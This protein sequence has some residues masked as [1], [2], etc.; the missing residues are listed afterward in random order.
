MKWQDPV[1]RRI[2]LNLHKR[3]ELLERTM[4]PQRSRQAIDKVIAEATMGL[5]DEDLDLLRALTESQTT[6]RVGALTE[7][8]WLAQAKYLD[9]I[10]RACRRAGW[11][12]LADFQE[13]WATTHQG[14]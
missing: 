14:P 9:L 2:A 13:S 12:C 11:S 3:I 7:C 6:G 4:S 1:G 10:E 5:S 8:E